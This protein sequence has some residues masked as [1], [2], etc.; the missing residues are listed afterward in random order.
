MGRVITPLTQMGARI[1]SHDQKP[2]LTIHGAALKGIR[3]R[4]EVPSAQV[5]S[6]ILLAGLQ[7]DGITVVQESAATRNHTEL[8][9][10]AFGATLTTDGNTV[11]LAG[12]QSLTRRRVRRSR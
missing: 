11:E 2:P 7:A 12:G 3:Y 10:R 6:A 9:L 1:D 4:T 8:A 5:K